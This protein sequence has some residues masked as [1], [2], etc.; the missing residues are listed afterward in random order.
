MYRARIAPVRGPSKLM[1]LALFGAALVG[2]DRD[3]TAQ[4]PPSANAQAGELTEFELTPTAITRSG[5]ATVQAA[6]RTIRRSITTSGLITLNTTKAAHVVSQVTGIAREVKAKVGDRVKAGDLL[7][8]IESRELADAKITYF[9]AIKQAEL[10]KHALERATSTL[11]STTRMLELL[12]TGVDL[13]LLRAELKEMTFGDVGVDLL[14][15]AYTQMTLARSTYER[16][17]ELVDKKVSAAADFLRADQDYKSSEAQYFAL[18]EKVRFD[19]TY[20]LHKKERDLKLSRF[21]VAV[22]RQKLLTLG[23]TPEEIEAL[24]LTN[25]AL[26]RY[27]LRSPVS[28]TVLERHVSPGEAV[29]TS[30]DAFFVADL[31]EVWADIAVHVDQ[32][33]Q[34]NVGQ[35]VVITSI[36]V[37]NE[38][39]EKLSYLSGVVSQQTGA[40]T[41]RVV[42]GNAD[43]NWRPGLYVNAAIILEEKKVAQAVPADAIQLLNGG[44]V[45]FVQAGNTFSVRKVK[46]GLTDGS[47]TEIIEGVQTG[48]D[49]VV[50]NSFVLKAHV[51]NMGSEQ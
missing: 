32:L 24:A 17:K 47:F 10:G 39:S 1:A 11:A 44:P 49:C 23:L 14:I 20:E 43:G 42:L 27:E 18:A 36:A 34:V 41:G 8:V 7:C 37:G 35:L 38:A 45:V 30:L 3:E 12:S 31:L 33:E 5:I 13:A 19:S 21:R 16:E 28:G 40:V 48:E 51:L 46:L 50:K 6:E 22:S 26:T 15:P 25:G 2:C 29:A 9:A 4:A